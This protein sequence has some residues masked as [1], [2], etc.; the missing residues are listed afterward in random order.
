MSDSIL[1]KERTEIIIDSQS[2]DDI[3]NYLIV[4]TTDI[5]VKCGTESKCKLTA[6]VNEEI[7]PKGNKNSIPTIRI[8]GTSQQDI[9]RKILGDKVITLVVIK[10]PTGGAKKSRKKKSRKK[11]SRKKKSRKKKSRKKKSRKNTTGS[12]KLVMPF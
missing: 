8:S 10:S 7:C 4:N 11:K 1:L 3:F 6:I 2:F 9:T 12:K 5:Q